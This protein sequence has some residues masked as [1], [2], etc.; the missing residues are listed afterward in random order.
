MTKQNSNL[1]EEKPICNFY[2]DNW[3]NGVEE[4]IKQLLNNGMKD[5]MDY[6]DNEILVVMH[7][8]KKFVKCLSF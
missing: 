7:I 6:S 2:S 5:V 4:R 8:I 1:I 3:K